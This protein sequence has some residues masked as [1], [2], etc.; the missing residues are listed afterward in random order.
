MNQFKPIFLGKADPRGP[1]GALKRAVNTQKCIRAGGKHNDLDDVGKDT[2][3]HT[4]FEML[5]NWSF[6]DYFK[7]EA[8]G[9]A[10]ELLTEVRPPWPRPW[11][12]P[13]APAPAPAPAPVRGFPSAAASSS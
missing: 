7:K 9:W 12:P 3:H 6:G 13:L 8:I 10:W 2:Y 5:G 4:F 1:M 11:A